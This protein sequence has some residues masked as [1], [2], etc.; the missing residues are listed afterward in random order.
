MYV[1]V[2]VY[3]FSS[4]TLTPTVHTHP[5]VKTT[6]APTTTGC[7]H[8]L[9]YLYVFV[10]ACACGETLRLTGQMNAVITTTTKAPATTATVTGKSASKMFEYVHAYKYASYVSI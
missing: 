3:A 9:T 5:V 4:E 8:V 7:V 6:V 2:Y 10:R 1:H